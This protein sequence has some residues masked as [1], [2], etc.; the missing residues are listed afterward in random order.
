MQRTLSTILLCALPLAF[1]SPGDAPKPADPPAQR[2]ADPPAGPAPVTPKVWQVRLTSEFLGTVAGP[3]EV[4]TID[5]TGPVTVS[6]DGKEVGQATLPAAELEP[7][8]RLLGAPALAAATSGPEVP[9]QQTHLVVTG[10]LRLDLRTPGPEVVPVLQEV[11][12]LRDLVGP[13]E[14]F[15][16]VAAHADREVLVSSNGHVEV[17]RGGVEVARH[18]LPVQALAQMHA[19]FGARA[20]REPGT[21][22]ADAGPSSLRITGDIDARGPVDL[23]VKSAASAMHAEVMR[24]G[25]AV[26]AKTRPLGDFEAVFTR[27]LHGAGLGPLRTFTVRARDRHLVLVDEAPDGARADRALTDEEWNAL[28]SMLLDPGFR[29]VEGT[30]PSREGMVYRVKITGDQPMDATYRGAPPPLV[31]AL[32]NRLDY[33]A[34]RG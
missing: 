9:G 12:R 11:D 15:T 25:A 14:H 31:V 18:V 29:L 33:L 17:K 27:Q 7:L 4:V 5:S 32:L 20:L 13:P 30:P 26:E 21:W 23:T 22:A 34:K 3:I 24:L 6:V 1:C 19:I 16:V 10:D 28:V 2:P 8:A